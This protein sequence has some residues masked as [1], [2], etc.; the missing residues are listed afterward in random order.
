SFLVHLSV[1]RG[2]HSIRIY[3]LLLS[4]HCSFPVKRSFPD[5]L[6]LSFLCFCR[7][8]KSR[9][10]LP[11]VSLRHLSRAFLNA[12]ILV[13]ALLVTAW[14]ADVE[15]VTIGLRIGKERPRCAEGETESDPQEEEKRR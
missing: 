12:P 11:F 9:S 15:H 14:H 13:V 7:W 6:H 4:F 1:E 5:S 3:D 10:F 2:F 8:N